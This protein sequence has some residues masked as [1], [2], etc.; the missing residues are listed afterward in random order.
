MGLPPLV[1]PRFDLYNRRSRVGGANIQT[2]PV[3]GRRSDVGQL[4]NHTADFKL[5]CRRILEEQQT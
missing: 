3:A 1:P 4:L 2:G 5:Y